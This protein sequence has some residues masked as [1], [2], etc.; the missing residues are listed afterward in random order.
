MHA[1]TERLTRA[2]DPRLAAWIRVHGARLDTR[3]RTTYALQMPRPR[4]PVLANDTLRTYSADTA[5]DLRAGTI[6]RAEDGTRAIQ[7]GY[8]WRIEPPGGTDADATTVDHATIAARG[9]WQ[10]E[11]YAPPYKAH[12]EI[13]YLDLDGTG[14]KV[15]RAT[16]SKYEIERYEK[17]AKVYAKA[18]AAGQ[19]AKAPSG[20]TLHHVEHAGIRYTLAPTTW[21]GVSDAVSW[22]VV[23]TPEASRRA[24]AA[25]KADRRALSPGAAAALDAV[26][27]YN[28]PDVTPGRRTYALTLTDLWRDLTENQ[29]NVFGLLHDQGGFDR[30]PWKVSFT[31]Q[32]DDD[33][34]LSEAA[35]SARVGE[36]LIAASVRRLVAGGWAQEHY[37]EGRGNAD[38]VKGFA[39]GERALSRPAVE[40]LIGFDS[41]AQRAGRAADEAEARLRARSSTGHGYLTT[42][43]Y[44]ALSEARDAVWTARGAV[45]HP[46]ATDADVNAL[47]PAVARL[48]ATADAIR[49]SDG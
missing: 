13:V 1:L 43:A 14:R 4:T 36:R 30:F 31:A 22:L 23:G 8:R 3:I 2:A 12:S 27:L 38:P 32:G 39:R 7:I 44:R 33:A 35:Y 48:Q 26:V 42:P 10:I 49:T 21:Y 46:F 18:R 20:P 6:L 45:A 34:L 40:A 28:L 25:Q 29:R 37:R 11:A 24:Q 19:D 41:P 15:Y 17:E 16:A 5:R 9:P 47:A